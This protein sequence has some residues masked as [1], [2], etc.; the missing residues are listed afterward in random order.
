[1]PLSTCTTPSKQKFPSNKWLQLAEQGVA[2]WDYSTCMQSIHSSVHEPSSHGRHALVKWFLPPQHIC[3]CGAAN[4]EP[5]LQI[6]AQ[7]RGSQQQLY[8]IMMLWRARIT[9]ID[10]EVSGKLHASPQNAIRYESSGSGSFLRLDI[11]HVP[12]KGPWIRILLMI[13]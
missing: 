9:C 4:L 8:S 3:L 7:T 11:V 12:A 2:T 6:V 13:Y 5:A 10:R 1:M